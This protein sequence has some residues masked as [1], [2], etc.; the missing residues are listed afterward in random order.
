MSVSRDFT[1]RSVS[2]WHVF[3]TQNQIVNK[4]NIFFNAALR[5][6]LVPVSLL[7]VPVSNFF[8]TLLVLLFVPPFVWTF[9]H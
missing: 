8:S 9:I 5:G 7:T 2:L 1:D 6:L 3:S 4:I